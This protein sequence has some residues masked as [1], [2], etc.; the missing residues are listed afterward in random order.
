[1]MKHFLSFLLLFASISISVSMQAQPV[2]RLIKV[3]VGTDHDNWTYRTGENVNFSVS[4]F[5]N[6][7]LLKDV[8]IRYEIGPE[9]MPATKKETITLKTGMTT[10]AGGSMSTPGFLRCIVVAEV[11]GKEYRG[12]ATAG[13]DP[14]KIQPAVEN[15]SDFVSFWDKAK[16]ELAKVPLD[17]KMTL[18]PERC[19]EKVNVYHVN[20][21]NFRLGSRVYGI[22]CVPKMEGKFP[23]L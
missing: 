6:G 13:I 22:L 7:N 3:I 23:A 12:L 5:R 20:I 4:V 15:P 17:A 16:A 1:M 2:E 21:Q 11:E 19:T 18:M 9:K 10:L 14:D 8:R